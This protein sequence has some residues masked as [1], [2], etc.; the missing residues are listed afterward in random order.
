MRFVAKYRLCRPWF[1]GLFS[2]DNR[3][4]TSDGMLPRG[5]VVGD[6]EQPFPKDVLL[7]LELGLMGW[8]STPGPSL[9]AWLWG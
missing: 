4:H 3:I 8:M 6:Q 7:P 9:G 5:S 2:N 1:V